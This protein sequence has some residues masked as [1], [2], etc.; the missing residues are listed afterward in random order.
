MRLALMKS[1]VY[2]PI[3]TKRLGT[4]GVKAHKKM[5]YELDGI[6]SFV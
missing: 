5:N 2:H 6:V 3:A 4:S 1:E